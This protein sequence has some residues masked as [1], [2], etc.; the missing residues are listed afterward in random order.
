[1]RVRCTKGEILQRFEQNLETGIILT[2][3]LLIE[4]VLVYSYL[5]DHNK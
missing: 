1:M 3:Y 5:H 4:L 2:L